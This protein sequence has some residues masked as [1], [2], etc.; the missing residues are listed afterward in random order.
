MTHSVD[1]AESLPSFYAACDVL[2]RYEHEQDTS[3]SVCASLRDIKSG[4][5]RCQQM[6]PNVLLTVKA[7]AM[8]V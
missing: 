7:T 3:V 2:M 6:L 1:L 4:L 5:P 8:T